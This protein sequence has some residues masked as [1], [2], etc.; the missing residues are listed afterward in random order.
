MRNL[1]SEFEECIGLPWHVLRLPDCALVPVGGE[2]KTAML[3]G[4]QAAAEQPFLF[5]ADIFRFPDLVPE[6]YFLVGFW[7]Y[8]FNSHAFYYSV[9]DLWRRVLLRLPYGGAYM[10]N[11]EM[12]R[13]IRTFLPA[14]FT[15]EDN[16]HERGCKLTAID[17]MGEGLYRI[18]LPGGAQFE[19][20]SSLFRSADFASLLGELAASQGFV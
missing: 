14:Y 3:W 18:A 10:D 13:R 15:F 20:R 17:S 6:G 4:T 8:G 19:R 2:A 16:V 11:D 9:A 7:G 1:Q 5:Q 12:A